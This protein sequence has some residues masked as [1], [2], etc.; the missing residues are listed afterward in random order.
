MVYDTETIMLKNQIHS[1][2]IIKSFEF[3]KNASEAIL[4]TVDLK[5]KFVSLSTF[6]GVQ[7]RELQTAHKGAIN[8]TDL[9]LNGGYM[10]TGGDDNLI[11][12]WDYEAHKT[13]PYY[14]QAFIGHSSPVKE[15]MFNPFDNNTVITTADQDGLYIWKFNGDT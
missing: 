4:V 14:F 10:I 12:V 13:M 5:I 11:K 6:D 1:G 7:L 3:S 2:H 15:V 9:S 8:T